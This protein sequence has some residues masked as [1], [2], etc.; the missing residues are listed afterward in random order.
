MC[1]AVAKLWRSTFYFMF[2]RSRRRDVLYC[3]ELFSPIYPC[4]CGLTRLTWAIVSWARRNGAPICRLSADV[5]G[6]VG[7]VTAECRRSQGR[8]LQEWLLV[9][10]PTCDKQTHLCHVAHRR[11]GCDPINALSHPEKRL[12]M[13]IAS[14]CTLWVNTFPRISLGIRFRIPSMAR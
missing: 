3:T 5:D 8:A 14:I 12:R 13:L 11:D 7:D 10:L 1:V 4:V 2:I 9:C 6:H